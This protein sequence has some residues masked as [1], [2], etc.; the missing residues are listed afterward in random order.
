M[1]RQSVPHTQSQAGAC[2]CSADRVLVSVGLTHAPSSCRKE[3][4]RRE[5]KT[6]PVLLS[7]FSI[8]PKTNRS[9]VVTR[10]MSF[11]QGNHSLGA[12]QAVEH[13]SEGIR[14]ERV[15]DCVRR[16]GPETGND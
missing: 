16:G 15:L 11:I 6:Y 7:S 1:H 9:N 2:L 8:G 12:S 10:L 13:S 3:S 5:R 4:K 14:A